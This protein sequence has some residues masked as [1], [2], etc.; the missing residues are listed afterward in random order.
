M[1]LRRRLVRC[2][3]L[4]EELAGKINEQ[5]TLVDEG[6]LPDDAEFS[7]HPSEN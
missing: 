2:W 1:T 3:E 5:A 4:R 7:A 6:K